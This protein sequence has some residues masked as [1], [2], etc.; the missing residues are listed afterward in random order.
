M[1][2]SWI[3]VIVLICSGLLVGF[4][5]TLAGGGTIISLSVFMFFGLPPMV[6]NGTNRIAVMLQNTTAVINFQRKKIIDWNKGLHLMVPIILGAVLG[7]LFANQVSNTIFNYAFAVIAFLVGVT[8][9]FKPDRWLKEKENLV[10]AP[11]RIWH[12]LLFFVIGIYGGFMHVGIGYMI[13]AGLV[14]GTG[15]ELIKANALKNLL[16][17]SY[18]PFSLIVFAIQ[19]NV[20]WSYGLIHAIGNIIGAQIAA[21]FAIKKG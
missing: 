4:I 14:L 21:Q 17:L 12:Y 18:V 3:H 13:L 9:I 19:G 16:V 11:L 20:C 7:A 15:N 10:H 6:A 5:N 1:D 2:L 8:I